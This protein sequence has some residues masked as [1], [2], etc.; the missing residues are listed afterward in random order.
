MSRAPSDNVR[1]AARALADLADPDGRVVVGHRDELLRAS[2]VPL[3]SW[4]RTEKALQ[5]LGVV[6]HVTRAPK[7]SG[8]PTTAT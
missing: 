6:T 4:D 8:L 2:G 3:G 5:R 7:G 1:R